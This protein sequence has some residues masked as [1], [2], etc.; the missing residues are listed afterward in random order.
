MRLLIK[1][2]IVLGLAAVLGLLIRYHEGSVTISLPP[3]SY[4]LAPNELALGILA[5]FALGYVVVRVFIHLFSLPE[6]LGRWW[7]A[8]RRRQAE[9][10][11]R[12]LVLAVH[13]GD[14]DKVDKLAE[15]AQRDE[16]CAG[17]SALMAARAAHLAGDVAR[18]NQWVQRS[19]SAPGAD[20]ARI[21]FAAESA[22]DDQRPGDALAILGRAPTPLTASVQFLRLK[23]RALEGTGRWREVLDVAAALFAR[24]GLDAQAQVQV[25]ARA[26]EALFEVAQGPDEVDA[27][28]AELGRQD[29][30]AGSVM[31]AAAEAY[32]RTGE[33]LKALRVIERILETRLSPAALVL[34]TRLDTIPPRDR[35]R[36][37][38]RWQ[39]QYD[40]D[41]LIL[42]TLGRLCIA[43]GLWGKAEECLRA[44]NAKSPSPFT[45][46]ALA[47]MYEAMGRQQ[48]ASMLYKD[49]A[50][51]PHGGR[52]PPPVDERRRLPE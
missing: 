33:E 31:E 52:L 25:R 50:R 23:L 42:A 14:L 40:D 39:R 15:R 11:L 45:R 34:F 49:I 1:L 22:L 51:D 6:S 32:A 2:L 3:D 21:M 4:E 20:R 30:G 16:A 10:A 36:L 9:Q 37:A 13:E 43:E 24:K 18:R 5:M 28:Y 48:D 26:Y 17:P 41:P 46:L 35:L 7:G 47:E 8:R 29:L 12:D 19:A 38:E 44:A 27:L